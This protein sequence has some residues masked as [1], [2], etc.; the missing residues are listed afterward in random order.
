MVVAFN[1]D[2]FLIRIKCCSSLE[3]NDIDSKV[4]NCGAFQVLDGYEI[5]TYDK[6]VVLAHLAKMPAMYENYNKV[7]THA[8]G[9]NF[10]ILAMERTKS[11]NISKS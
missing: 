8:M 6:E 3:L 4:T 2:L 11:F 10:V 1:F 7:R 5:F 9:V